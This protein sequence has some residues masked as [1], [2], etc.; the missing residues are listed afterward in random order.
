MN[1]NTVLAKEIMSSAISTT[2]P[3]EKVSNAEILMIKKN[4]GGLPVVSAETNQLIGILTQRDV[5]LSRSIIGTN[6]FHV[7]DL[8]SKNPVKALLDDPL[9]DIIKKMNDYNIERIP[10]VDENNFVQGIIVTQDIISLLGK[11]F[12]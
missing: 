7:D 2:T 3:M 1:L 6:V 8:Y 5:Q 9:P 10:V 12:A 4:I 11:Y